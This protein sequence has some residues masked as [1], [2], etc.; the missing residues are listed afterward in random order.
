[1]TRAIAGKLPRRAERLLLIVEGYDLL[2]PDDRI[3]HLE[4]L[5][6]A[7]RLPNLVIFVASN[8]FDQRERKFF[9][10]TLADL[11]GVPLERSPTVGAERLAPLRVEGRLA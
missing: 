2:K 11:A 7:L 3:A 4:T 9:D 1:F 5:R 10:A 8:R 6:L